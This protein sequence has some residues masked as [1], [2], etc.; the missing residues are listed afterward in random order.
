MH[1]IPA[2][3]YSSKSLLN[4]RDY[5]I[6]TYYGIFSILLLFSLTYLHLL[7][8]FLSVYVYIIT[9]LFCNIS[10]TGE[11]PVLVQNI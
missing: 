7:S 10:F 6:Y 1:N 9:C 8:L 11:D 4:G 3:C 5:S 2:V